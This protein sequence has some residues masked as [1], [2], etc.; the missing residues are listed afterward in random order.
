MKLVGFLR[1]ALAGALAA[2]ALGFIGGQAQASVIHLTLEVTISS[3][4]VYGLLGGGS[5]TTC[6]YVSISP[7]TSTLGATILTGPPNTIGPFNG[8]YTSMSLAYDSSYVYSQVAAPGAVEIDPTAYSTA[9][10]G[11]DPSP[12]TTSSTDELQAGRT[13]VDYSVG[14]T[15]NGYYYIGAYDS[16]SSYAS[17][18]GQYYVY[19]QILYSYLHSGPYAPTSL[20]DVTA[21]SE[22]N[23]IDVLLNSPSFTYQEY[24]RRFLY[25]TQNPVYDEYVG[26]FY[27]GVA[28]VV[29]ASIP[30][31]ATIALLG[32]GLAGLGFSRRR[33]LH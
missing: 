21:P 30:E 11:L 5:V 31:P 22:A 28:R 2:L 1:D 20:A 16:E 12:S 26:D 18:T 24:G 3:H 32:I 27:A 33:K 23:M 14:G 15:D 9:L 7:T 29:S 10:Q 4:C 19:G 17:S 25:D 13:F 6:T 8:S